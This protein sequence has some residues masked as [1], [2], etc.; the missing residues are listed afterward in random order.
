MVIASVI[1]LLPATSVATQRWALDASQSSLTY[2]SSKMIGE[3]FNTTI[4]PNRFKELS[5]TIAANGQVEIMVDMNSV[6]TGIEIRNERVR[7]YVFVTEQYP[8][9]KITLSL[10]DVSAHK[11]QSRAVKVQLVMRG[12]NKD[13]TASVYVRRYFTASGK[14]ILVAQSASP[15][16]LNAVN[17]GMLDGF[18]KL[19]GLAKLFNITT[20]IPVSFHLLFSKQAKPK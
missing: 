11:D 20:T 7:K 12:Q 1:C 19:R 2:L 6:D 3:T 10:P 14:E 5:G 18:E 17:Y 15:I 13:I 8:Y 9:A 4:E 16:L